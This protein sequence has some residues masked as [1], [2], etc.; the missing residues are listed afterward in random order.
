MSCWHPHQ[1][2]SLAAKARIVTPAASGVSQ[3]LG[4]EVWVH[5]GH[6]ENTALQGAALGSRESSRRMTLLG[7]LKY[8]KQL[9]TYSLSFE[10]KG[11]ILDTLEIQVVSM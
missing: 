1:A 4:A 10:I 3:Q 6:R 8:L 5:V 7:P 9:P 2:C 11:M